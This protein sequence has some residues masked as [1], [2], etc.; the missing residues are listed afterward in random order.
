MFVCNH[1]RAKQAWHSH[2]LLRRFCN[3]LVQKRKKSH[4]HKRLSLSSLISLQRAKNTLEIHYIVTLPGKMHFLQMYWIVFLF[5][6]QDS[7]QFH[8]F[9]YQSSENPHHQESINSITQRNIGRYYVG[10]RWGPHRPKKREA[11]S[12]L[13]CDTSLMYILPL[14]KWH[15]YLSFI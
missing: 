9:L 4:L 3:S 5:N 6:H 7:I 15:N 8:K 12:Q 10:I 14:N 1:L 11:F 13:C 2:I